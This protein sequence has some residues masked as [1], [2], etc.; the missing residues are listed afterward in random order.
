MKEMTKEPDCQR[1]R[2]KNL[3]FYFILFFD[4]ILRRHVQQ[5]DGENSGEAVSTARVMDQGR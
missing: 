3:L 1:E 4:F 5:Q 2:E